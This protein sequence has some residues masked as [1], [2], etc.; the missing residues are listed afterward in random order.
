MR[1]PLAAFA[2]AVLAGCPSGKEGSTVIPTGKVVGEACSA[3][4]QCRSDLICLAGVCAAGPPAA[5]SCT[6]PP[7]SPQIVAGLEPTAPDPGPEVCVSV[8]RSPVS[9]APDATVQDLGPL[10]VGSSATFAV[11]SGVSS[12]LLFQQRVG[13]TAADEFATAFGMLTNAVTPTDLRAPDGTLWYDDTA[14]Y[15][16]VTLGG[17][18]YADV[19]AILG[20]DPGFQAITAGFPVPNTSR[21]LDVVRSAGGLPPGNWT[22]KVNDWAFQCPFGDCNSTPNASG[23]YQVHAVTHTLLAST[24]TLDVEVYLA[25]DPTSALSTAAVAV[26]NPETARFVASLGT[27]LGNAGLCLG[28]VTF[29]D[30]PGWARARYAANGTV[31]LTDA[32]ACGDLNQ[33]FTTAVVRSRAVHLFLAD[34]LIAPESVSSTT[35]ISIAGVDGSIPGPSGFPGTINGGAV[36]GLFDELG[37]GS[38]SGGGPDLA[39][40]GTDRVAYVAAHEIG[41]WLGL[42]HPTEK[43]G[44]WFDPVADT[45]RCPCYSCAP[46]DARGSCAEVS[47]KAT[48]FMTND[49]CTLSASCGGGKNLMFWL[50]D[51][52]FS[53]GELSRDQGQIVRLNPA[54]R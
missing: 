31:D 27:F 5:A 22:F 34:D 8:V 46:F 28:T 15:P 18:T 50:L 3:G 37:V 54:V 48:T 24:G 20:Y 6:A 9:F 36:V 16:S 26:A 39:R 21:A 29:H 17:K 11:T 32:S 2:L 49:R 19:S 10:Q 13:N 1:R 43:D 25:T 40:C 14:G 42:F 4:S 30:L 44:T 52:R 33:L 35:G 45:D 47:S 38:C 41:H 12:F 23:V 53:T 7:G 51:P